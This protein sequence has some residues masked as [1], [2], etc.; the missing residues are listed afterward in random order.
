MISELLSIET[1]ALLAAAGF[2]VGLLVGMTGVGAGALMTPMLISGFGIA[3]AVAVGTDLLFAAMTKSGGAWR[4]HRLGHVNW[5]ILG[6][7]AAGSI[8]AALLTLAALYYLAP[9][10]VEIGKLIRPVLA[11]TLI[12]S[13]IA[14]PV[15]PLIIG[16]TLKA[17]TR[18]LQM[19]PLATMSF[20]LV[21]GVVV[22]LTSVGAGAIGV[23]VLTLLYPM[24][25]ARHI[26]GTDI[27]HAVPLTLLSGLGHMSVGN[28]D[29]AVLGALLFGSLPGIMIG[30]RLTS[31]I[32]DWLLRLVLSAVLAWAAYLVATKI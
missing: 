1:V 24:L 31:S 30:S 10:Q 2:I 29:F 7:L 20:G 11:V 3:P 5:N 26:V 21:L 14:V 13:A 12:I 6:A 18:P 16:R 8:T 4:H 9:G 22:T 23:A 25:R 17:P 15:I 32:P 28:I 27:V 19:R